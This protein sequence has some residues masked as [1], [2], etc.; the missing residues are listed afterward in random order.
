M[1]YVF[2]MGNSYVSLEHLKDDQK[3]WYRFHLL[4]FLLERA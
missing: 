3:D 2:G 1:A 4:S